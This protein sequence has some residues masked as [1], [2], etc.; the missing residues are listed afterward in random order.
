MNM[1]HVDWAIIVILLLLLYFSAWFCRKFMKGV[2]NFL[3]AGRSVG[4][5]LGLGSDAMQGLGAITILAGWQYMYKAGFSAIWWGMMA[6]PVSVIIALTGFG[7]YRW[8]QTRAMTMGQLIEMR[9]SRNFRIFFGFLAFFSGVINMGIFPVVGAN[10]IIYFCGIP[11]HLA[12][13]HF[14]IPTVFLVILILESFAV[15]ICLLGGQVTL[16]VTD[17][18]QS[19]FVAVVLFAHISTNNTYYLAW[20]GMFIQDVLNPIMGRRLDPKKHVFLLRISVIG[21]AIFVILFSLLFRQVDNIVMFFAVTGAIF[22]SGAG[23]VVLGALYWRRTTKRAAWATMISG[24]VLSLAGM[25]L[26]SILGDRMLHGQWVA[27]LASMICIS[28]FIAISLLERKKPFD[29]KGILH[30]DNQNP[31]LQKNGFKARLGRLWGPYPVDRFD[32]ILCLLIA[33]EAIL[34]AAAFV[35]VCFYNLS[36][37]VPVLSWMR[38][39]KVWLT[40]NFFFGIAMFIWISLG[41]IRDLS[42]L[43]KA[44]ASEK[45]DETDDGIVVD[46]KME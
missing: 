15:A 36:H 32:K 13:L 8:R 26:R 28:L 45:I 14:S 10:F 38:F 1:R 21:V 29:L 39:F 40:F 41:G 43:F 33:L 34:W 25:I 20:G 17:F 44:L 24:A 2:S 11:T 6:F 18:L 31:A 19:L 3:V 4:R 22:T 35:S 27:F 42:R 23:V 46:M 7:I 37:D 5:Y 12:I 30:V 16:I 9:Y